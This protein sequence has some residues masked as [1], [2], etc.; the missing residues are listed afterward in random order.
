MIKITNGGLKAAVTAAVAL[1]VAAIMI[2]WKSS[3]VKAVTSELLWK[4]SAIFTLFA[5]WVG[6]GAHAGM[7]YLSNNSM[8]IGAL[9][10]ILGLIANIYYMHKASK[11]PKEFTEGEN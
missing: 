10:T 1:I 9:C 8:G 3:S 4:M 11:K 2:D 7:A 5:S 6:D